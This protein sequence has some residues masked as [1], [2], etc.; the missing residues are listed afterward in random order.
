MKMPNSVCW[1]ITSRCND[2]CLFCYRDKTS[3]DLC[4]DER[5]AVIDKIVLSG[6]KKLTFA[7]GEPLLLP[8]IRVLIEYAKSKGLIVSL[9]TNAI[10]LKGEI[11]DFCL[12]SLNWLSLSLDAGADD[13]QKKMTRKANHLNRVLEVLEYASEYSKRK[14]EIKI[15]TVV[16]YVNQNNIL[17]IADIVAGYS[18][19]RWKLFQF[20][21]LRGNAKEYGKRFFISDNDFKRVAQE[22]KKYLEKEDIWLSISGQNDIESGYFVIFPNG[23]IKISSSLEDAVLGNALS[24]NLEEIWKSGD[25]SH[26]LHEER[27]KYIVNGNKE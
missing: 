7:G 19:R 18:V 14:C 2:N 23:D 13:I 15:N 12:E 24:D 16:S 11:L 1:N 5:K 25:Y 8:E 6:I 22:V 9:T 27:T 26:T 3:K 21:P 20:V 4:L 10:L 17:E